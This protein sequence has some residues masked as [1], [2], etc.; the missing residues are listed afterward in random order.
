MA[1]ESVARGAEPH[2]GL[3]VLASSPRE[4][5]ARLVERRGP[6]TALPQR[7]CRLCRGQKGGRT[8]GL[9]GARSGDRSGYPEGHST[10]RARQILP[11]EVGFGIVEPKAPELGVVACSQQ[12][13]VSEWLKMAAEGRPARG[14]E[15]IGEERVSLLQLSPRA[16]GFPEPQAGQRFGGDG[17]DLAAQLYRFTEPLVGFTGPDRDQRDLAQHCCGEHPC[18][19]CARS[20]RVR[21]ELLGDCPDALERHAAGQDVLRDAQVAVEDRVSQVG[22]TQLRFETQF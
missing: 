10:E 11:A 6:W 12:S 8:V 14:D 15:R 20:N 5:A 13:G 22:S 9:C 21:V 16:Y 3:G 18:A 17:A 1:G 7:R 19:T 2:Q 4:L